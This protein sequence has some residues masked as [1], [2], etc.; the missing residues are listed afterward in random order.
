M[1][2]RP[3]HRTTRLIFKGVVE[4]SQLLFSETICVNDPRGEICELSNID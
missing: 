2:C 4:G 3:S 1:I